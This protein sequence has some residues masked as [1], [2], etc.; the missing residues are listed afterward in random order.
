[1]PAPSERTGLLRHNLVVQADDT[2]RHS[3]VN[4]R[5]QRRVQVTGL[6]RSGWSTTT[7]A[8]CSWQWV[9]DRVT[10]RVEAATIT[11]QKG[12]IRAAG[13]QTGA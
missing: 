8:R 7:A 11:P 6:R 2:S 5:R 4:D 3:S 10:H 9:V 13:A 12:Y 1:M